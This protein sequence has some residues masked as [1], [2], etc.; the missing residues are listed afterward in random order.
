MKLDIETIKSA[1]LSLKSYAYQDNINLFL[2]Q[3]VASFESTDLDASFQK[4]LLVL[5]SKDPVETIEFRDWLEEISYHLLPK[6]VSRKEDIK[7]NQHNEKNGLFI[8]NITTS[9]E[10]QVER[11]NYFIDAPVELH[12]IE[13][14][15]CSVVGSVIDSQLSDDCY[16][17]RLKSYLTNNNTDDKSSFYTRD[18]FKRYVDQYNQ[19]RDQAI[20][21]ASNLAKKEEDVALLSL[22]LKSYFYH[23][24]FDF[25]LVSDFVEEN[26]D[27]FVDLDLAKLL[28]EA[29]KKVHGR[30][31]YVTHTPASQTHPDCQ[32]KFWLPIGMASSA[33]IANWYL[34]DFDQSISN[35]VRPSYYGRYVDDILLVFK[36]PNFEPKNPIESF[37]EHYFNNLL[38]RDAGP[39]ADYFITVEQNKLPIQRDKLILQYFDK[40]HSKA[41]LDIF[42]QELDERSSAFRFL[43][44]EHI[45]KELDKFAYDVLYDGSANKLRSIVGLAENETELSKYLSSH[46]TAHRLCKLDYNSTVIPEIQLFFRGASALQFSRLW[47]KVYQ[48]ALVTKRY[49]FIFTFVNTLESEINKIRVINPTSKKV[50]KTLTTELQ[51]DMELYNHLSLSLTVAL[52][53][54]AEPVENEVTDAHKIFLS[55]GKDKL[56]TFIFEKQLAH[57]S[58]S[59]RKSNLLRHH[60]VSW[61]LANFADFDGD[62]TDEDAFLKIKEVT[63]CSKKIKM[64]PRFIHLDEWQLFKL[65]NALHSNKKLVKWQESS[66]TSYEREIF[67]QKLPVEF[68]LLDDTTNVKS[69]FTVGSKKDK[70]NIRLAL[71]NMVVD[72]RDIEASLRKDKHSNVS[73]ERQKRLYQLLNSAIKEQAELLIMPE[74]A[75]PVTWLPF[76]VAHSRRHQMGLIFGLEHWVVGKQVYNLIIEV[77]PFKASN[78]YK[79]CAVSVRLKNHYAPSELEIIDSLRL[80]PA[81]M[82][83]KPK[84]Y[85]HKV[86]WNGV[87]FATYNCFELSDIEH[88]TLFK[89]EVD[90]IFACVWN[91][92]TNYYQHIL[93]SAV[94][95]L[96]CYV[97]QSNTSQY[98]GSCVLRPSRTANK[99]MLYVKGGNNACVL[100]TDVDIQKL[101]EFQYKSRPGTGDSFKHLPPGYNSDKVISR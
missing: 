97:V 21:I 54:V 55:G 98:G 50:R 63:W 35:T 38:K 16:G 81:N 95:D 33:I 36:R 94:R 53:D 40:N 74:V 56:A 32:D 73:Y 18:I 64:S 85:Y 31:N 51:Q 84:N 19:W 52:L 96:H 9:T 80:T 39:K 46:I 70:Q 48:Y 7:Q 71:A 83:H 12:I 3:R 67:S 78:K 77:L 58:W 79:S 30:Y 68:K 42:K 6:S 29:L 20:E 11:V 45:D 23:V 28:T 2:K 43:P 65:S 10:Y 34:S 62:L 99:T 41:G 25:D 49:D 8:S 75:I 87:S 59:F 90:M 88:R 24:D 89:S 86:N 76:M 66:L 5:N 92:D 101:R 44:T 60:L 91:K 1:Y 82:L 37:I 4:I 69:T 17:N 22:D 93:E 72:E 27:S 61:P 57:Y 47:E 100:T 14:L 15:W 13:M 26:K